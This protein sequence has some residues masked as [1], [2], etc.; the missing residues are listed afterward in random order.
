MRLKRRQKKSKREVAGAIRVVPGPECR[1]RTGTLAAD[2]SVAWG[3]GFSQ[4]T[5]RCVYWLPGC[6]H[7]ETLGAKPPLLTHLGTCRFGFCQ[8][9]RPSSSFSM[10]DGVARFVH[11]LTHF[12]ALSCAS[13]T[14]LQIE[15]PS[16]FRN[17]RL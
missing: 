2:R 13:W 15:M 5:Q 8:S 9:D 16:Y 1:I 4:S 10:D 17:H 7:E 12:L 3:H 11:D 6:Q 14:K